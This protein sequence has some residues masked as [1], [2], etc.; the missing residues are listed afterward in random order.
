M[1]SPATAASA[2]RWP[3]AAPRNRRW[4]KSARLWRACIP[5]RVVCALAGKHAVDMPISEQVLKVIDGKVTP[6]EAVHELLAREPRA[7]M[8]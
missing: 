5:P 4:R 2:W 8:I 3:G 1:T 6:Q 7:E